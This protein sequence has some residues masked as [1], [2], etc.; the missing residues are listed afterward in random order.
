[1]DLDEAGYDTREFSYGANDCW[2]LRPDFSLLY[3]EI[4]LGMTEFLFNIRCVLPFFTDLRSKID[5][6]CSCKCIFLIYF[7]FDVWCYTYNCLLALR[8]KMIFYEFFF[9]KILRDYS[10]HPHGRRAGTIKGNCKNA[11]SATSRL[12]NGRWSRWLPAPAG[13]YQSP[14]PLA[15]HF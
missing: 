7:S 2:N 11:T 4:Q 14:T 8:V 10:S 15:W 13:D 1:M 3:R 6:F 12:W 9:D 5:V